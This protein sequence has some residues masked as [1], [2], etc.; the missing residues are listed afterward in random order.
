[1]RAFQHTADPAGTV[2]HTTARF[3]LRMVTSGGRSELKQLVTQTMC[4]CQLARSLSIS[5]QA[6]LFGSPLDLH[7]KQ[8]TDANNLMRQ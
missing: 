4:A 3:R 8:L 5:Q 7:T 1:V 2:E 6:A